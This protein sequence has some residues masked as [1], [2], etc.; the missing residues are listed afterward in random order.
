MTKELDLRS[1]AN[2]AVDK[3]FTRRDELYLE[4]A[5]SGMS[6]EQIGKTYGVAPE[7]VAL[8][9][10]AMLRS[11][12]IF[13]DYER[14]QLLLNSAYRFKSV[15]DKG[16]SAV[17]DDPK[18][19]TNYL[20]MIEVLSKLLKDMGEVS[21]RELSIITAAQTNA[22][23][24]AVERAYYAIS[25]YIQD[26]HPEVDTNLLNAEFRKAVQAGLVPEQDPE[27]ESA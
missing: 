8:R 4:A 2:S 15:M 6:P 22:I 16:V 24:G 11:Q 3:G 14:K 19:A 13:T 26:N 23:V 25:G 5:E 21:A 12:D 17:L 18:L 7:T 10:K 20:K 1:R 9:I 27:D